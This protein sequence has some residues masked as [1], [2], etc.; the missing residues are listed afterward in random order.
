ME[1][2]L[3]PKLRFPEFDGEWNIKKLKEVF[4]RVASKNK[5]NLN[6]NVLTISGKKGLINQFEYYNN[7]YASKDLSNYYLISKNDFAYNKSY[8]SGYPYGAIK[9]LSKYDNGV[10]SPLYICFRGRDINTQFYTQFFESTYFNHELY[11]I[12]VE[13]ARNHGLLNVAIEDFFSSHIPITSLPEQQKIADYLST[14]DSKIT[15]LEEKKTELSRYKKAMMQKLFSQEIRFKDENGNDF[16]DWEK[17]QLKDILIEHKEKNKGD[18]YDE[19]LSVAKMKGVINQIEHLGRSYSAEKIDHYKVINPFDIVYTKSPT[20]GFPF[21]IIK[22]NKLNRSG[23]LSPLYAVFKPKTKYLGMI[24]HDIFLSEVET[25]N[26]LVPLVQ[27]GA[28]NTMNINNDEFLKGKKYSL[29]TSEKE[30]QKIADFLS[31]I[32][33]SIDKVSEQI[34]ETQSFKK[35]MLQQMFV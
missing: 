13:G 19:V 26:Y 20:S 28:K 12:C 33:E 4:E 27:K 35:A 34:K 18:K 16:S 30:Q 31:A 32:D 3:Q 5:N 22:Q 24:L 14:I 8:S 11:K 23:V 17:V 10:L 2:Q 6:Q 21:G 1:K 7:Q 25:Y 15:L 29:P 9:S